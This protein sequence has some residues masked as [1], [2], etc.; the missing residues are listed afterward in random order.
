MTNHVHAI[1]RSELGDLSGLVRDFK[2]YTSKRILDTIKICKGESLREWMEMILKYHAKY[3]KRV[4]ELQLWTHENHAVELDANELFDA[5]MHYIH[6][7]PVRSG[8]VERPEDY[9]YSSARNYAQMDALID[10]D[11]I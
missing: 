3:N 9:L 8:C 7:N 4:S 6:E 1:M 2:R 10:V 5:R 11:L